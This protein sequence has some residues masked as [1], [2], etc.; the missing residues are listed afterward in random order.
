MKTKFTQAQEALRQKHG[1]PAEFAVAVYKIVP[2]DISMDE[3][4]AAVDKYTREWTEA[5]T[6]HSRTLGRKGQKTVGISSLSVDPTACYKA[7]VFRRGAMEENLYGT[8]PNS[9][10][11]RAEKK[12]NTPLITTE[13]LRAVVYVQERKLSGK[14]AIWKPIHEIKPT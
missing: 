7:T 2:R 9:L 1:T 13:P 6:V 5:G 4:R 11:R 12:L 3:A 10:A 8:N 14:K